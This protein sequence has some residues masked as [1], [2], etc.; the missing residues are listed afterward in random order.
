MASLQAVGIVFILVL[1]QV[2][3]SG[4]FE[5]K[6]QEFFN[7]QGLLADG[8]SCLPD[9]NT[10]FRICLKHYQA[11][12]SPG[13]CTFGSVTTKVL[14]ERSFMVSEEGDS[15]LIRLPFN[16]TWPGTFSLII[17]ASYSPDN[18]TVNPS[19]MNNHLISTFTIQKQLGMGKEWTADTQTSNETRLRYSYRVICSDN[20][21]TSSCSMLC[22]PRDDHF[23]HYTCS[24]NGSRVCLPGWK[25]PYC[26]QAICASSC[27]P[28]N[29]YCNTPGGCICRHGWQGRFC[30]ECIP[31]QGCVHGTCKTKWECN[32][33]EGWGGLLCD[34][35]LNYCTHHRPCQ[36]GATCTNT[37]QGSYTC[38]CKPG[39][40][41]LKCEQR[42]S[43]CDNNPCKNGGSCQE[44][45][46]SYIC[47]CTSKSY[48]SHCE[49]TTLTCDESP[50]FNGGSC[51]QKD[52]GVGYL[53]VCPPGFTGSNCERKTSPCSCANDDCI[54]DSQ[55]EHCRCP[56]GFTGADCK[57]NI[58]NCEIK[59]C[60][61]GG[62]CIDG[63]ND[64]RC[65][66]SRGFTG[67][68]C[69]RRIS[70]CA[71][72]PCQNGGTC[73]EDMYG[74][75]YM[76]SCPVGFD[77]KNC[78][79]SSVPFAPSTVQPKIP[80]GEFPWVAVFLAVGL[81]ALLIL[82]C[83]IATVLRHIHHQQALEE[84]DSETM[85]NLTD[86]QKQN[87]IPTYQLKN[88][89]KQIDLEVDCGL[90][91]SNYKQKNHT[92]DYNLMT[93]LKGELS[94]EGKY[95]KGDRSIEEEKTPLQLNSSSGKPECRISTICSSRDSMYQSVFVIAEERNECVIATEV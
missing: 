48:G 43:V 21:Y 34:H 33:E 29:G 94:H 73:F 39:F 15:G 65:I 57:T 46:E 93:D 9:C 51:L 36:N 25:G 81:M 89:N 37:G 28:T 75:D 58:N 18:V 88:T 77:G 87:L 6:L 92:W 83:M 62:S 35:D 52:N 44:Q 40:T 82:L 38:T 60:I 68:N 26:T 86:F 54:D 13:P 50:C 31:Y 30:D 71:F 27:H 3:G 49:H 23:G 80:G 55:K 70:G 7:E 56:P 59:R 14:G 64:Y 66:C 72:W 84:Q 95:L 1:H 78:E 91:K 79:S 41:G 42:I 19:D 16:F 4:V 69:E 11:V 17:N 61:N 90:E 2:S 12:V 63:I 32:C 22:K 20:Y 53:C 76:C 85:N 47:H 5:L 74:K 67:R 45:E 10:F 8:G 24:S